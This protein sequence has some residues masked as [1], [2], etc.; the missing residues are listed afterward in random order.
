MRI[1]NYKGVAT[2]TQTN[3]LVAD[4]GSELERFVFEDGSANTFVC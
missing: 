3:G 1:Y 4:R 2:K